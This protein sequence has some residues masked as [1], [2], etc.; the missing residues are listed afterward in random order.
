MKK[1]LLVLEMFL[2]TISMTSQEVFEFKTLVI[3]SLTLKTP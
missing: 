1:I 2:G 3:A